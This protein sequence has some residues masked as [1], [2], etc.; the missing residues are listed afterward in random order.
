MKGIIPVFLAVSKN[1]VRS[2]TGVFFSFLFPLLLLVIFSAVFGGGED[3]KLDLYVQNLDVSADGA[4]TNLS[5]AFIEALDA[6]K[7]F[8]IHRLDTDVN[9][10][11]Y[12]K[13]HPSFG[14]Y[15]ALVIGEGFEAKALNR[16]INLR[17]G[18]MIDTMMQILDLYEQQMNESQKQ[19]LTDGIRTM[20]EWE[21]ATANSTQAE[22]LLL[23]DEKG[24]TSA[25][26]VKGIVL[27]VV[28]SFNNGLLLGDRAPAIDAS[29]EDLA[30]RHLSAV[31]Y[32]LPGYIA[33]FIMTNGII[34]GTTTISEYRRNGVLKRLVATPLSKMD[35]VLGNVL[36]QSVLAFTLTGIMICVGWAF[37]GVQAVPNAYAIALIFIGVLAFSSVGMVL[38]GLIKDVEAAAG[39]GNAI[40]FPMMFLSGAFWP[41][42]IMPDYM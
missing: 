3:V 9:V 25:G 10:T 15:R 2:K 41:I 16:S 12:P 35:W 1:W 34:G 42:E 30:V 18:V 39:A 8:N 27:S 37:F 21:N 17:L 19:N 6:T 40:A 24:D 26:I 29:S 38:G 32:Y 7:A 14:V 11:E 36:M 5:T 22:V 28:N 23:L 13:K 4:E 33:A 20:Q 31:D